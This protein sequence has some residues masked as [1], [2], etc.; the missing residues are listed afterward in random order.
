MAIVKR[1]ALVPYRPEYMF[2]LVNDIESYPRFLPWCRS[3]R[4]HSRNEDEVRATIQISKG[5]LQKSFTTVN[6]LQKNKMMEIRL[7]EGPFRRLEGFWLFDALGEDGCKI[8]LDLNFEFAGPVMS[9]IVGPVFHQI[10]N[11]LVDSF[12]KR[13]RDL[14]GKA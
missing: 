14:H 1:S 8:S 13:A 12:C 4:I 6:R 3:T 9:R 10:A 11:S 5:A 7:V 2:G